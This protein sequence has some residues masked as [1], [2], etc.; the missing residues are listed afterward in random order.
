MA[1]NLDNQVAELNAWIKAGHNQD[2]WITRVEGIDKVHYLWILEICDHAH[3]YSRNLN[4][5]CLCPM[6]FVGV[7]RRSCS[8]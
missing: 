6:F 5:H 4:F 2:Q 7:V 3:I 1:Q 8:A